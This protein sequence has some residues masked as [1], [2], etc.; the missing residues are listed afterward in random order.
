MLTTLRPLVAL[1]LGLTLPLSDVPGPDP[2]PGFETIT[3][4]DVLADLTF[5][6]SPELEGRDSPSPGLRKA[7]AYI[8]ERLAA[9]GFGGAGEDGS[10][11]VPFEASL[12]DPVVEA[13]A[14]AVDGSD[15]TFVFGEHFVPVWLTGGEATGE[16]VV[17]GFGIDSDE[18]KYDD[19]TGDVQGRI[20][21]I[22][23]GEP[24]H[25]RKFDGPE[26][27]SAADL[28]AKLE[29][30]GEAGVAGV[31]VARRP[32]A[33]SGRHSKRDAAPAA[34]T[35]GAK[36][37]F[38]HTW[39][40]WNGERPQPPRPAGFPVLEVT[41]ATAEVLTG[42]DLATLAAKADKSAKP[43]RP[44]ETG[45]TLTMSA[46]WED[47]PLR[48]DNVVGVLRGSD[49][50]LA[51]EYIV[52]GAH[53]DHIGVDARGR[54]G[55]GADDNASGVAGL[56]E[57]A[58]ALGKHPPR[59]SV[60]ACAFAAEEDGLVGSRELCANPPV[61]AEHMVTMLNMDMIGRGETKEVA[62][63]G[64]TKN[65]T[66]DKV[67]DDARTFLP[68]KIKKIVTRQGL[69]LFE[70]SDHYSF[71]RVG[72]PSLFFFE[73]LPISNNEDYHTWRDTLDKVDI[74]KVTRTTRLVFSTA[75]ILANRDERAPEPRR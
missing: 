35:S 25:R 14:L 61:P 45:R 19:I 68:T 30:L 75:W 69:E 26:L 66:L 58:E 18:D 49:P 37:S 74:D 41:L 72:V 27:S 70:R 12:P 63:L 29:S 24:R 71:H 16:A 60:L 13:C 54:I 9:A 4:E 17:L 62:V 11:L 47:R 6:A 33:D 23:D 73:G 20:A 5:L 39:A 22:L 28:Y 36:L 51:D 48:I 2:D 15:E 50:E 43:P 7:A 3:E 65:P 31:I 1:L 34:D 8:S 44:V 38:R 52:I 40:F 53:Y 67:L 56:L 59:R 64:V 21:V 46:R 32:E 55:P 57:T 10:F 42:I